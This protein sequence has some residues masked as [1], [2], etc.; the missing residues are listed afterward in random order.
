[1]RSFARVKRGS[2][3]S[4]ERNHRFPSQCRGDDIVHRQRRLHQRGLAKRLG[5]HTTLAGVLA[6]FPD[7]QLLHRAAA[8]LG[9]DDTIAALLE[10]YAGRSR[11]RGATMAAVSA[12]H[13]AAEL[14]ES[15]DRTTAL[16]LHAAELAIETGARCEAQDLVD[17]A[18]LGALGPIERARLAN[19]QEVIAFGRYDPEGRIFELIDIAAQ[20]HTAGNTDLAAEL[21]WRAASRSFFQQASPGARKAIATHLRDRR[22]MPRPITVSCPPAECLDGRSRSGSV[23]R[24]RGVART[25]RGGG[26]RIASGSHL[27]AQPARCP[28]NG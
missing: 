12:L 7:K 6:D 3:S 14:S 16:L 8:T 27:R 13:R 17:R 22:F 1:M 23:M 26:I 2:G 11:A 19:V 24:A 9:A 4:P 5:A 10:D 15:P 25:V 20:V 28:A 21:L 18:N